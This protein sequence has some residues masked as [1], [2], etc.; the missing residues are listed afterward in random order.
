MQV[1]KLRKVMGHVWKEKRFLWGELQ[2]K[3]HL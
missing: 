1:I 2:G 3:R